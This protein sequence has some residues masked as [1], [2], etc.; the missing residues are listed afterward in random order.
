MHTITWLVWLGAALAAITLAPNPLYLCLVFMA[1]AQVFLAWRGDSPLAR[2]FGLFVRAGA[3]I[4]LGYVLFSLITVG[5]ARG[6]TVLL[7]LPTLRLPPW[8]GGVVLGGPLTA[9]ALAWGLTRGLAIWALMVVF[10]AFNALVDHHRLLRLTPRSLFHAGLAVTIAVAFVPSL[11]RSIGEIGQAQRARGHRFGGPRT[12]PPLVSPLLA[13]SLERSVQLAE[14]LDARGYGRATAGNRSAG[15]RQ[16]GLI[17]GTLL[18]GA[19]VFAWLYYGPAAAPAAGATAACGARAMGLSLRALGRLVSRSVYRRE[20]WRR[21]DALAV[22]ACLTCMAALVAMRLGGQ[23]DLVYYPFPTITPPG[24]DLR[25]GLALLLLAAPALATRREPPTRDREGGPVQRIA[26]E[27]SHGEGARRLRQPA[28]WDPGHRRA[29]R[30]GAADRG[31]RGGRR[32]R[33]PGPGRADRRR[34]R[35][36]QR[37]LHGELAQGGGRLHQAQRGYARCAATV[38]LQQRTTAGLL[39]Q[40]ERR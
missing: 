6:T 34:V 15:L 19:G 8:L 10:G 36:R 17:V 22:A 32:G 7:V 20:R 2:S 28:R 21:R 13:G 33:G 26:R 18:L 40:Q 3:F 27:D 38:A 4:C 35:G 31:A 30:R 5:G 39:G 29:D 12:W 16:V 24:F 1:A 11:L 25:A 23:G 9:E 14:A 37:G